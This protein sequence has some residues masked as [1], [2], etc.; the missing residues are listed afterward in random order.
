MSTETY[1]PFAEA[2]IEIHDRAKVLEGLLFIIFSGWIIFDDH[3]TFSSVAVCRKNV[4]KAKV[5]PPQ[6]LFGSI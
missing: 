4:A 3:K 2:Y 1:Q 6:S 5:L